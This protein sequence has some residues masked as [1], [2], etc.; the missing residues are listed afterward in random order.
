VSPA[1]EGVP[2]YR[3]V[4]SEKCRNETRDFLVR[5]RAK[6]QFK[7]IARAVQGINARLEWIPLD[8][9]EPLRDFVHLGIKVHIGVLAPF[10]VKYGV[11]EARHI[12]YV[13]LPF[14]L[15]PKKSLS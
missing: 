14:S 1:T 5:A 13:T 10:V 15:L 12:V 11:D 7:E 6:S 2:P 9:G 3:V 8:F 4:Y